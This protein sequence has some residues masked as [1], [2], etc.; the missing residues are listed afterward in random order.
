MDTKKYIGMD[1]HKR[2]NAFQAIQAAIAASRIPP[3]PR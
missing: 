2:A 3:W 1:V